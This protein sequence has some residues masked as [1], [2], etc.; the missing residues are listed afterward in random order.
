M[1]SNIERSCVELLPLI[2]ICR[3]ERQAELLS[4]PRIM[5]SERHWQ[6]LNFVLQ[7]SNLRKDHVYQMLHNEFLTELSALGHKKMAVVNKCVQVCLIREIPELRFSKLLRFQWCTSVFNEVR[8][9]E[10]QLLNWMRQQKF[11][12]GRRDEY[13]IASFQ[14]FMRQGCRTRT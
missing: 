5:T 3:R 6:M 4:P 1:H 13:F 7:T 11:L 12:V 14:I 10:A 9:R 2:F 8:P